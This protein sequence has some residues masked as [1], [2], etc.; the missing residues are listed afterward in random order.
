M[1]DPCDPTRGKY[2]SRKHHPR[3]RIVPR[4]TAVLIERCK[5]NSTRWIRVVDGIRPLFRAVARRKSRILCVLAP[6]PVNDRHVEWD[7]REDIVEDTA[8]SRIE[9]ADLLK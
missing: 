3:S 4:Y 7:G 6:E 9:R 1:S 5:V 2:G 8:P